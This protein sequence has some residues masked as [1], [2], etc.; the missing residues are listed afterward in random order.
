MGDIFSIVFQLPITN[1]LVAC[2]KVL[3]AAG[4][5]YSL[6]FAIIALTVIVRFILYPFA[7]A[8]IKS[9]H[10]MQKVTPHIAAMKEKH[11]DD[12]K[13]Q[14]EEM[15]R[16][17]KEHG[18]NPASGCLPLLIQIPIFIGIYNVLST[19]VNSGSAEAIK[20]INEMLYS[21]SLHLASWNTSFF[22]I[23]LSQTPT[24][25]LGTQPAVAL[26]LPLLTG[27]TQFLLSKMMMPEQAVNAVVV[28]KDDKKSDDFQTMFQQQS[29]YIFPVMIGFFSFQFPAGLSLYWITFTLFGILQQYRLAG[30]GALGPWL[31]KSNLWMK[32]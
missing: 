19:V 23:P 12:K 20:K 24:Q 32:N 10:K 15:L 29:L 28:K 26:A 9:A 6:G 1:L 2:Y 5:P 22:G 21:P 14:Q 11:K 18:V 8:Q 27:I 31:K 3:D 13:K 30:S 25:L 7:A 4:V 17:Y 16:L